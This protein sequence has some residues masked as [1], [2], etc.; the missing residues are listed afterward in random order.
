MKRTSV[1]SSVASTLL[2]VLPLLP[3]AAQPAAA[4]N[5]TAPFI[6][7]LPPPKTPPGPAPRTADGHPDLSG[8]WWVGD[9]PVEGLRVGVS[10]AV[11]DMPRPGTFQSLYNPAAM[12]KWRTLG[13]KDD[14]SLR[15]VPVAFGTLSASLLGLGLVGQIIQTPKFVALLTETYHSFKLVPTDGRPHRDDVAPS[16]RGDS[17]GRWDGDTLVVDTT[18]FSDE[19]WLY[20]EGNASF[21][22][23]ALHIVERYRRVDEITLQI[24]STIEDPK[25]LTAPYK[26]PTQTLRLAPFDQIMELN[27]TSV[28]TAAPEDAA[29]QGYGK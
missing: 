14:P 5:G 23:D 16:Y 21:H 22:S 28:E 24:D 29:R 27:C 11:G 7:R 6:A 10:R 13:D 1:L 17:V 2:V 25:V 9:L 20:A 15:C 18:T 8:V 4:Q 12:A 19:N 26:V 3:W